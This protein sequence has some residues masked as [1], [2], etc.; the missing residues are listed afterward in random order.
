V[1]TAVVA[2]TSQTTTLCSTETTGT[3]NIKTE[4][5]SVTNLRKVKAELKVSRLTPSREEALITRAPTMEA[6]GIHPAISSR[7]K[8]TKIWQTMA[9]R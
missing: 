1:D 9:S 3:L 7:M 2:I 5:V 6:I 8:M 4:S